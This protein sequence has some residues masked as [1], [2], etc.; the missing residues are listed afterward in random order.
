[1]PDA[2]RRD[3]Q[4]PPARPAEPAPAEQ[5]QVLAGPDRFG[6]RSLSRHNGL[7]RWVALNALRRPADVEGH[8]F[9]AA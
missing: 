7:G 6:Y 4:P 9:A 3:A 8:A 5:A 1:M 2:P